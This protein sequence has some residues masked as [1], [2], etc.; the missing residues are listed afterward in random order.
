MKAPYGTP[1]LISINDITTTLGTLWLKII[2]TYFF[3]NKEVLE[4]ATNMEQEYFKQI[5]ETVRL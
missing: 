1:Y 2:K 5:E 3:K 4:E